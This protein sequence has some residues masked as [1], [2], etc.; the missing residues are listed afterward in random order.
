MKPKNEVVK[1]SSKTNFWFFFIICMP[2]FVT[3]IIIQ[4]GK[5]Y[6]LLYNLPEKYKKGHWVIKNEVYKKINK[7]TLVYIKAPFHNPTV[8]W[9]GS[10]YKIINQ[11]VVTSKKD[12]IHKLILEK[13][14]NKYHSYYW[15]QI[16]NEKETSYTKA[17]L[18]GLLYHKSI[19][20]IN[21]TVR[22]RE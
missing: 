18:K 17:S 22:V 19:R 16:G 7:D 21:E 8:C 15:Y 1:Y 14:Q 9:T 20:L 3:S 4:K 2:I 10:G 5:Q 13:N 6:N 12:K 11:A